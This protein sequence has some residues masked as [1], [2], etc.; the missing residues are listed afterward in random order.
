LFEFDNVFFGQLLVLAQIYRRCVDIAGVD[1]VTI[2]KF[3]ETGGSSVESD[4]LV[5]PLKLPKLGT[6][7]LTM[8][9]G[10]S[11]GGT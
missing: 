4:I 9:G 1:Y 5:D 10:I 6:L 3:C 2:T 11:S 8:V 7:T